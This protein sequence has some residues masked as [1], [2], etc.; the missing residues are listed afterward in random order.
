MWKQTQA[1]LSMNKFS[2]MGLRQTRKHCP[3]LQYLVFQ[4]NLNNPTQNLDV[5]WSVNVLS[6]I[7]KF[8]ERKNQSIYLEFTMH[9]WFYT[10]MQVMQL[11]NSTC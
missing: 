5:A 9:K 11:D 4:H 6:W 1:I 2:T 3:K 8:Q 7:T 10:T